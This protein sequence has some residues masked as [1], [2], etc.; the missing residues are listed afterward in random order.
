MAISALNCVE[1]YGQRSV[2]CSDGRLLW[3]VY[4][5]VCCCLCLPCCAARSYLNED[6][7]IECAGPTYHAYMTYAIILLVFFSAGLPLGMYFYLNSKLGRSPPP[8][9]L[10]PSVS[11][12]LRFCFC[13]MS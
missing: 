10:L 13:V 9:L 8:S 7:S 4:V 3:C 6:Y 11:C 2:P 12:R 1:I 5:C